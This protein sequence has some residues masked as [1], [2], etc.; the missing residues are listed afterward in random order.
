M[1]VKND[2]TDFY[3]FIDKTPIVEEFQKIVLTTTLSRRKMSSELSNE[4]IAGLEKA[5][6]Q[7]L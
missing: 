4:E 6:N 2:T 3:R 7:F 5:V 1:S